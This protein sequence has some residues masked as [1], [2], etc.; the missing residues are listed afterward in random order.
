MRSI[1]RWEVDALKR[2]NGTASLRWQLAMAIAMESESQELQYGSV[3]MEYGS[4][5][6]TP[7]P[8]AI[9]FR[10]VVEGVSKIK[11]GADYADY[12]ELYFKFI[13]DHTLD[14]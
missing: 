5:C 10:A 9:L 13:P 11:L 3:A 6:W 1:I 2:W 12:T 14:K 7:L 4:V 8:L